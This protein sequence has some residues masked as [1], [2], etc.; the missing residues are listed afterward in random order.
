MA[1]FAE[2]VAGWRNKAVLRT[3]KVVKESVMRTV[4]QA[5][6]PKDDGGQMPV[7]T[8]FLKNSLAANV[9]SMPSGPSLGPILHQGGGVEFRDPMG[10][11]NSAY[12]A[13]MAWDLSGNLYV[14]W[15]AEY[16]VVQE[17]VNG[18][19]ELAAQNFTVNVV[20]AWDDMLRGH[21]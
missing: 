15:T 9:G 21:L 10:N 18:F 5:N 16:A 7:Y 14:G 12:A 20:D 11:P 2:Q 19:Q 8:G 17:N 13:I 1:S 4:K 3:H 6:T